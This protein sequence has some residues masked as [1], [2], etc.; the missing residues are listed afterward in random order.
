MTSRM[1]PVL[2]ERSSVGLLRENVP[3][4]FVQTL[5]RDYI[6]IAKVF[7]LGTLTRTLYPKRLTH[8]EL[9]LEGRSIS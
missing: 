2:T 8:N 4:W 3:E 5:V 7:L 9:W 6:H 1:V